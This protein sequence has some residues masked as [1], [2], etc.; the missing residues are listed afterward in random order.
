MSELKA[1]KNRYE[2]WKGLCA[3]V[4]DLETLQELATDAVPD[5]PALGGAQRFFH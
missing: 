1:L 4:D 3:D 5:V 2:P